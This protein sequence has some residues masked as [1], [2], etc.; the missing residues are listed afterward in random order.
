MTKRPGLGAG[1]FAWVGARASDA[2]SLA[3]HWLSHSAVEIF[4]D[5]QFHGPSTLENT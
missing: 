5:V 1:R 4:R 2:L 3:C